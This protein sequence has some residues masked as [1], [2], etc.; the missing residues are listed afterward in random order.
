MPDNSSTTHPT[1]RGAFDCGDPLQWYAI[2]VRS[3]CERLVHDH[4]ELKSIPVFLPTYST[5]RK[6]SDRVKQIEVPLFP[7]Y[8]FCR[9][10]PNSRLPVLTA[11]GVVRIVGY[12]KTPTPVPE[13]EIDSIRR[14]LQ[15]D[16][17]C[18]PWPMASGDRVVVE[19]GPL[20]GLEGVLLATK[21]QYRLSIAVNLLQRSVAAEIDVAWVRPL[22]ALETPRPHEAFRAAL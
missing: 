9:L 22:S 7:G 1:I 14:V 3:N 12:G 8:V 15:S 19:C 16:L 10:D 18:M 17:P 13:Q 6:W 11:P 5:R 2:H 4:L 20:A 21:G